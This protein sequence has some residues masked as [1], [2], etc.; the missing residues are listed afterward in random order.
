MSQWRI[1]V[2]VLVSP[3]AGFK[4]LIERPRCALAVL[5]LIG[6]AL[7]AHVTLHTRIDVEAQQRLTAVDLAEPGKEISDEEVTESADRALAARR[8]GGWAGYLLGIPLVILI[9]AFLVWLFFGAWGEGLG[10]RRSYR[11]VA[12]AL[13][14]FG[15]RQIL[16]V[17]I[18]LT[19]P[20]IDPSDTWGLFK[21]NLGVLL[22]PGAFPGAFVFDPFWIWAGV[23]IGLAG[24][25]MG[26]GRIHC[27][28]LGVIFW[29]FLSFF[30][31]F[32]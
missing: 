10:Y 30:G 25:A 9:I 21:T 6:C 8:L 31:Q 17:P 26:R 18:L 5:V 13:L 20:S 14:P 2:R 27:I 12:H 28:S 11:L 15:L 16:A 1:I 22:G 19:Y 32:L 3:V 23:L 24:R 7:A 4:A 29:L